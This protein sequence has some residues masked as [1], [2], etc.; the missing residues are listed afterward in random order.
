MGQTA[1][2]PGL[3]ADHRAVRVHA[4]RR[5]TGSRHAYVY[6]EDGRVVV[7]MPPGESGGFTVEG[8]RELAR[9]LDGE[10]APTCTNAPPRRRWRLCS[11][12][13]RTRPRPDVSGGA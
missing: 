8:A 2:V 3:P 6:A 9:A 7:I 12:P 13:Y 5:G 4:G 1:D 11:A 10:P